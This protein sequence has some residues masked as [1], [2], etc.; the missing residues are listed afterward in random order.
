[1]PEIP[2]GLPS[3]LLSQRPDVKAA[4]NMLVAETEKIGVYQAMRLPTF[5]LTGLLGLASSDI[6]TLGDNVAGSLSGMIT[7]PLLNS[8]RTGAG[9]IYSVMKR[10]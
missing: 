10:R 8:E 7:G 2:V 1:M 6:N 3:S 5:S 4:E 9:L